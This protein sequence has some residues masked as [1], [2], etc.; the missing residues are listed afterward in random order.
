[1]EFKQSLL[2]DLEMNCRLCNTELEHLV[3]D[4]GITPLS[5]AFIEESSLDKKEPFYPL[6]VYVCHECFLV[7]LD[8]NIQTPK[9]IFSKYLY[10]SSFSKIWLD[11]TKELA[12]EIIEKFECGQNTSVI[13]IASNDGY[14]LKHFKEK[15]IPLLGIEP[16]SNIAE[17]AEKHGIK[18]INKFFGLETANELKESGYNADILLAINV[19]PHVPDLHNFLKGIKMILKKDGVLILQF[20]TY[21]IP[22]LQTTEFDSIYH[23]HFS[24][25]SLLSIEK[26]LST[27]DLE[28]FDVKELSIHGGSLR[29]YVKNA[30]NSNY[31]I[32][33][34]VNEL[35]K[36]ENNCGLSVISEYTKFSKRVDDIKLK[37]CDFFFSAKRDGKKVV[38]YGAPA[39]G[40]TMLNFC[41]IDKDLIEYVVDISPHK[42]GLYLPGTH[43]QI[44]H[45]DI[46][47]KTKPDYVVIL[48]WNFKEE[49]M[50]K[51]DY[52]HEWNGKFVVMHPKVEIQK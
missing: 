17:I 41:G 18:T 43:I 42:Q 33:Q 14:L 46:I 6:R 22:F 26:I 50:E 45:P 47:R 35:R 31:M 8:G 9:N 5:N 3:V 29:L 23:E 34:S 52:I 24:Y 32:Q 4:L 12:C 25:F 2:E 13:E 37:I 51:M 21:M 11:H 44:K 38:C 30:N 36:K 10:F 28:I 39:K 1:V 40:N 20:S 7:Q 19:L 49:I 15:N 16:A 27:F 48:A